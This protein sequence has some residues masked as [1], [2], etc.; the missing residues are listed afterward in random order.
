MKDGY[1]LPRIENT[2][3]CLYGAVWFSILDVRLGYWQVE[4]E[5]EV[6]LLTAFTVGHLGFWEC[7]RMDFG[8]TN[9]PAT[10]QR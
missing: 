5:E 10:F 4:L 6:K 3:D 2:L 7:E 8:L 1:S 9:A